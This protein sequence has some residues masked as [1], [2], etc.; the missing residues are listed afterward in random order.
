MIIISKAH[1]QQITARLVTF[2]KHFEHFGMTLK[3]KNIFAQYYR[4]FAWVFHLFSDT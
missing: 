2:L 3:K 4:M 1:Q